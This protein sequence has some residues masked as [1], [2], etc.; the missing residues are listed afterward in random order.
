VHS[1]SDCAPASWFS[2]RPLRLATAV[3][4]CMLGMATA[5]RAAELGTSSD[6]DAL[7]EADAQARWMS[8]KAAAVLCWRNDVACFDK[9]GEA[10]AL[11]QTLLTPP[12]PNSPAATIPV[13][14]RWDGMYPYPRDAWALATVRLILKKGK[15][16]STLHAWRVPTRSQTAPNRPPA[17]AFP[18]SPQAL[19]LIAQTEIT[20]A[21][22]PQDW[23]ELDRIRAAI[24]ACV[25]GHQ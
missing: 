9:I 22:W 12:L 23:K 20:S 7:E 24:D 18:A 8:L 17:R 13:A 6:A 4:V 14:L 1:K 2:R 10:I 25:S 11:D 19:I 3:C 5:V 16:D 21:A 15:C